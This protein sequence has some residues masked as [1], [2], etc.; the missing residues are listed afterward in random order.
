ME[1]NASC[2]CYVG[3][4]WRTAQELGVNEDDMF[5]VA[6]ELTGLHSGHQWDKLDED[7]RKFVINQMKNFQG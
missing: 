1:S 2:F 5:D 4:L 3:G 6:A 7:S